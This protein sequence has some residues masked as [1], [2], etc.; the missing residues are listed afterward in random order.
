MSAIRP[1]FTVLLHEDNA[2]IEITPMPT[3]S[4]RKKQIT[5]SYDDYVKRFLP[6]LQGRMRPF[7]AFPDGNVRQLCMC[8]IAPGEMIELAVMN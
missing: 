5:L 2:I 8:G 4:S 1:E 7:D 3:L 6:W